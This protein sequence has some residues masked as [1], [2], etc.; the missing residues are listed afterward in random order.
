MIQVIFELSKRGQFSP[1]FVCSELDARRGRYKFRLAA[2][3]THTPK[4]EKVKVFQMQITL[5]P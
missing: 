2:N 1:S 4:S 3:C 5:R